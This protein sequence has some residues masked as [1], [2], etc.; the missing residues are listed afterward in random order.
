MFCVRL[1]NLPNKMRSE[2]LRK[3]FNRPIETIEQS[4]GSAR[5]CFKG[6]DVDAVKFH[7]SWN[8]KVVGN[9]RIEMMIDW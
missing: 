7:D 5:I 6:S 4:T 2:E 8:G 1:R 3:I 9:K